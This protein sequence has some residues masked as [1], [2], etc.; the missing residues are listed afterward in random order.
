VVLD[1]TEN[2]PQ[3]Q[4]LYIG[5]H[6]IS[7]AWIN[8]SGQERAITFEVQVRLG[9]KG[10]QAMRTASYA[11]RREDTSGKLTPGFIEKTRLDAIREAKELNTIY[12]PPRK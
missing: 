5:Y 9:T 6:N 8:V 4:L 10:M 3:D 1:S 12:K 11:L 2:T 7:P